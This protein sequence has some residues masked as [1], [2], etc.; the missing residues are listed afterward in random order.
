MP[1]SKNESTLRLIVMGTGPFAVPSFEA[2]RAAGHDIALVV[3]KP[4]PPVKSRKGP[5]PSPV[6]NWATEHELPID[7]P[8]SIND[9]DAVQRITAVGASLL[10]VCDYG[11]IL[12][13]PALAAAPLGGI[14]LHGS[15]LPAYRGA[16]PVQ[17]AL[18]SG[19]RVTGVTVIHMTPKLDGGPILCVRE[20]EIHDEETAGELEDRLSQIGVAA[21]LQAVEMLRHWDGDSEIGT[22][23]DASKVS[24]APRLSKAEAEI[25][26]TA[27]IRE[28]DCLVRGM[29]PWPIAFTHLRLHDDKPPIRLAIKEVAA[30]DLSAG[31][32]QAGEIIGGD[33]FFVAVGDGVIEIKRLQPAGKREMTATEFLRGHNPPPGTRFSSPDR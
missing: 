16:A 5:P 24:K 20:T 19:D 28:I 15:L 23:Q 4:Q 21:T 9:D 18:L 12:K 10:V 7:D 3:T 6:R 31:A 14:N 27:T 26:W 33:G 2:L 17:R 8:P 32:N 25:D 29:Q 1:S 13:P 30:T 11:Q 22:R